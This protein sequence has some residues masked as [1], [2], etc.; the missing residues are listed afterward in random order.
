MWVDEKN[1]LVRTV[2]SQQT[3]GTEGTFTLDAHYASWG[4]PVK[5]A[6]PLSEDVAAE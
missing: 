6:P 2:S 4:K 5:I 1:N 3:A